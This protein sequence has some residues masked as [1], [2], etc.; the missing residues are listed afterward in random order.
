MQPI[1]PT[2]AR[3]LPVFIGLIYEVFSVLGGGWN[4]ESHALTI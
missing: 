3:N 2:H 1:K 4:Y